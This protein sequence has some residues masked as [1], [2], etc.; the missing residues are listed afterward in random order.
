MFVTP[1]DRW[2]RSPHEQGGMPR[3]WY[4]NPGTQEFWERVQK[5]ARVASLWD[6]DRQSAFP[7]TPLLIT[8]TVVRAA[9]A[10]IS[11]F[12][13]IEPPHSQNR[14]P[15]GPKSNSAT[16]RERIF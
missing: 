3:L 16:G 14:E 11:L 6:R 8:G 4:L 15:L 10:T 1:L 13:S 7:R 9:C 5:R 2:R 12:S